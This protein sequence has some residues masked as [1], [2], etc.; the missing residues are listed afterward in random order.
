MPDPIAGF[1][2]DDENTQKIRGY[3]DE[4][5]A[6]PAVLFGLPWDSKA[7]I[8]S[9]GASVSY[10]SIIVNIRHRYSSYLRIQGFLICR[11]V[12]KNRFREPRSGPVD[13]VPET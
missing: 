6:A 11:L 12:K 13:R 8:W 5:V 3:G 9:V 4:T 10:K 2:E 7:D 1:V